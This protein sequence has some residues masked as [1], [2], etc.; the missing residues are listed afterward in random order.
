MI[1]ERIA[2]VVLSSLVE[3]AVAGPAALVAEHG[4]AEAVHRIRRM[5]RVRGGLAPD[6]AAA[7][8]AQMAGRGV[9]L[10]VP[11]D[12]E[13]P[14]QVEDLPEPPLCLWVRGPLDLRA[15][16]LRSVAIV[17][18][19]ACTAYGEQ[20]TT[21]IAG[22]LADLAWSVISGAAFGIDAVAHRAALGVQAATVAVLAGGVDIP[23]P[24]AHE[25]LIA[26]IGDVGAVVSECPPGGQPLR[27][28]F[29]ARNRLI[30]A[31]SR[32]TV[33]VEAAHR[34]GALATAARA[35][36]LGRIVMAVPGPITS[37]ASAGTNRLL[38]EQVARAVASPEQV[39]SLLTG[40]GLAESAAGARGEGAGVGGGAGRAE[41]TGLLG[42]VLAALPRR[43][44]RSIEEVAARSGIPQITCLAQLGVLELQG[45]AQRGSAGWRRVG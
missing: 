20:A 36:E 8:I 2:R 21:Q 26:R 40:A 25:P 43:G 44:G 33:V 11:D 42:D 12:P 3:P 7:M 10:L 17:G 39:L 15:A 31:L 27:H 32:G 45:H 9:R 29:L 4:A 1:D 38:H 19:R 41:P 13:W 5:R 30:A 18:S 16:A 35:D 34:S 6:D 24:R 37:M 14:S 28:R 23:Y 22:G